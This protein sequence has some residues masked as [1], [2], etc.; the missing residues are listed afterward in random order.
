M[1]RS[2][3]VW[4][5]TAL[6]CA[7]AGALANVA[8]TGVVALDDFARDNP[9]AGL[10]MTGQRVTSVYGPAFSTG[11][12][13]EESVNGFIARHSGIFGVSAGELT[14]VGAERNVDGPIGVMPDGQGGFKFT[15][16]RF[17]HEYAGLPVFR[18]ELK[19]L[20][21]NVDGFPMTLARS[22]LRSVAGL[23]V[24]EA[25]AANPNADMAQMLARTAHPAL[26]NFSRPTTLIFAGDE[27]REAAPRLAIQFHG[28]GGS[29]RTGNYQSF[30]FV[31]DAATGE[32]LHSES[33]L[34]DVDLLGKV[35]GLAT[36]GPGADCGERLSRGSFARS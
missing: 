1:M 25:I 8:G 21:R 9:R 18:S 7:C 31:A 35:S 13:A 22:S 23:V 27:N 19:M 16:F 5:A 29:H 14:P 32:I 10:H 28:T 20:V 12:S 36:D 26:V 4:S 6:L 2:R 3:T 24:D 11:A 15:L 30:L 33:S 34:H 17:G